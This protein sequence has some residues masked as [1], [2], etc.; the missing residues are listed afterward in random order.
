MKKLYSRHYFQIAVW[1]LLIMAISSCEKFK[2]DQTIP[3]YISIDTFVLVNNP[4]IEEGPLS[5][6]IHDVWVFVDDQTIGPFELPSVI[7]I[8]EN[9]KHK[10]TI[11]P[12]ILYS[13]MSGTRGPYPF[14]KMEIINDYDFF[15]DSVQKHTPK[16]SYNENTHFAWD[17]YFEGIYIS[18]EATDRS[19]T[20]L[21][22]YEHVPTHP[23]LGTASGIGYL[24]DS[25]RVLECATNISSGEYIDLPGNGAPVF[26]ELDYNINA[27]LVIGLFVYEFGDRITQHPVVVVNPSDGNWKKIYINLSATVTGF[28]QAEFFNIFIRVDKIDG[29]PDPI[30]MVDNFKLIHREVQ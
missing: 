23:L 21:V 3:S 28:N 13:G 8:L 20:S 14:M 22:F 17:E 12:G 1:L 6:D 18:L 26:L 2:G 4:L 10:L 16:T 15:V 19:D 30:I 11:L 9:G 5:Q 29:D 7:P 25:V 27:P 24:N